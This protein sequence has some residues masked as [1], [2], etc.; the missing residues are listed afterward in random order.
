MNEQSVPWEQTIEWARVVV[1]C[2]VPQDGKYLFIQER[3]ERAYGLWNIPAGHVDKDETIEHAAI[4]ETQEETGYAVEL[5]EEIAIYHEAATRPVKHAYRA[6]IVSGKAITSSDEILQVKWL[7][8]AEIKALYDE[9]KIRSEWVWKA[10]N[11]V[12]ASLHT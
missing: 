12:E 2:I 4:R 5:D 3:Q 10:I 8:Y 7:S 9:G 11:I 1:G 6:H